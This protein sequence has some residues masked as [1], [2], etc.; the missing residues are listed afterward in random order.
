MFSIYLY[1]LGGWVI[2]VV[3]ALVNATI[4]EKVYG[5]FMTPLHAHQISTFIMIIII[6]L[7][8]YIFLGILHL[9]AT[10]RQYLLLGML[11]LVL[12]ILFEFI[13]GHY[14]MGHSWGRLLADYN[15]LQGRIWVLV[16]IATALMPWIVSKIR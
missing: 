14:V 7:F 16:L 3:L 13:F 5:P 12:T 15:L 2:L 6:F 11:W 1:G 4:R 10:S 9:Q 8:T